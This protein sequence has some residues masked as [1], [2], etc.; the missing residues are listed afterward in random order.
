MK[1]QAQP[2]QREFLLPLQQQAVGRA[3]RESGV[4]R[5]EA[6]LDQGST[7]VEETG[8]R[9]PHFET[10]SLYT[11][12]F[13]PAPSRGHTTGSQPLSDVGVKSLAVAFEF[14]IG[15]H[16]PDV[17]LLENRLHGHGQT[18]AVISRVT[19]R[20]L[21]R[22]ALSV[23]IGR[24]PG[25]LLPAWVY[26]LQATYSFARGSVWRGLLQTP[27]EAVKSREVGHAPQSQRPIQFSAL[28][29][30]HLYRAE[31]QVLIPPHAQDG[32]KL[33]LAEFVRAEGSSIG[34]EHRSTHSSGRRANDGSPTST[35]ARAASEQTGLCQ[36]LA[37]SRFSRAGER[38]T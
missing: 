27:Q 36:G 25:P 10:N 5:Q 21:I 38:P 30:T 22:Y 12:A 20:H 35:I 23:Q 34:W 4:Y 33:R 18:R 17:R 15:Q 8:E 1:I 11:P 6:T 19:P 7:P 14:A 37:D 2:Q 13:V 29:Q 31:S 28:H 16:Q 9:P 32:Q 3:G 26:T 24:Q